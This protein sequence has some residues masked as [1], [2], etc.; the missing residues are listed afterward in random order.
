MDQTL[1]F[2]ITVENVFFIVALSTT[3]SLALCTHYEDG[4]PQAFSI[5]D[6]DTERLS[7]GTGGH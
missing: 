5:L 2:S 6:G 4:F 1:Y 7:P 3:Q